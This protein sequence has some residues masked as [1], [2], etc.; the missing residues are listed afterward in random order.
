MHAQYPGPTVIEANSIGL[1]LIQ[2]LRIPND[3]VI[4]HTTTQASKQGMLT[5][6]ELHLQQQTLKIHPDF[7]QLLGE[8]AGYHLPDKAI[9]QD[10]VM[11]LGFAVANADEAHARAAS[12]INRE[13]FY[14]LNGGPVGP[15]PHW[16]DRQKIT[17]NGPSFGL[18]PGHRPP[19][20]DHG[21]V[22]YP[23]QAEI[24]EIPDLLTQGWAPDDSADLEKFGYR[25][26]AHGGLARI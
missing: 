17:T 25:I 10:S 2:N 9:V 5:E 24:E 11:A 22:R 21:G 14:E 15:P 1:P 8:L 4:E 19:D 13:L 12:G 6:I 16:L 23:Y 7:D 20:S 26:D 18:I 3:Q